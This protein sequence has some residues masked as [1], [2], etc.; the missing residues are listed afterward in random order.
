MNWVLFLCVAIIILLLL[1][2][3]LV[4]RLGRIKKQSLQIHSVLDDIEAG[5]LG[6]RV[7]AHG[8]KITDDICYK[9]NHIAQTYES[10]LSHVAKMEMAN[11]QLMTS[12]SHDVRTPLT[13]LIGYLDA[14]QDHI[15]SGKERE[16]YIETART[17]AYVLKKYIDE[18]F[19]WFKINSGE[20]DY[21]FKTVDLGELSR[22]IMADWIPQLEKMG[23]SYSIDIPEFD[24]R[25]SID[26]DAYNRILNNL[27][28]NAVEHSG[29]SHIGIAV[30]INDENIQIELYDDGKGIGSDHIP[31][32]FER[33]YKADEARTT[34]GSG[35]GLFIVY[36]LVKALNATIVVES[37]ANEKTS[38]MLNMKKAR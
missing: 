29:G 19:E 8:D 3:I 16:E 11:Q 30:R 10:Q 17:K 7:V 5:N 14:I 13:T 22:N 33:L 12:L 37:I 6:R 35:L 38:F 27:I 15:V 9:I 21:H 34:N 24:I 28:Q 23:V 20:Q 26:I 4:G 25:A 36:E 32:I 18:L 31:H 1:C 2:C